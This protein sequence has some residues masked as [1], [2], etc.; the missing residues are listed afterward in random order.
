MQHP[1]LSKV[2][3]KQGQFKKFQRALS[4]IIILFLVSLILNKLSFTQKYSILDLAS[5]EVEREALGTGPGRFNAVVAED[6]DDDGKCE[7]VFGNY[8]GYIIVLEYRDYDFH[9]E[10]RSKKIGHRMWGITVGDFIGDS[11]KEIIAGN[12]N[13][14]LVAFNA[15]TH[16]QVWYAEDLVRDVHGLL[17]HDLGSD[18]TTYLLAGTGYKTDKDLGTVYIF[19]ENST[20][21]IAKIGKFENRLRGIGVGDVDKDG[22]LEIV[23]GS[24]VATG[25]RPGEGYVRVF[26]V[27]D[28]LDPQTLKSDEPIDSEWKSKNLKG[29]CV[30]IEVVDFT[31]D[32]YPDIVV[33][34][35]YRYQAGW[36]RILTYDEAAKDYVEYW[37]SPDIGPKPYGLAVDDV[38]DNNKL[39]IVVSN[40]PGY[41]Y[42]YEQSGSGLKRIWKSKVLGTDI[43]G[44]DIEDVDNDGQLEI[45]ATQGGYVGKG[46]YT[47][48]YSDPHIY[49]IDGKTHEIEIIIGETHPLGFILQ[50][51]ILILTVLFLLGLNYY[52]KYR[53]KVKLFTASKSGG[54][55]AKGQKIQVK[56][57]TRSSQTPQPYPAP[58]QIPQPHPAQKQPTFTSSI[59][60]SVSGPRTSDPTQMQSPVQSQVHA[61]SHTLVSQPSQ[62]KV[63]PKT[64][65]GPPPQVFDPFIKPEQPPPQVF[66][67]FA[68][69]DQPS[70]QPPQPPQPQPQKQQNK[71]PSREVN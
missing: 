30:A 6:I 55:T 47:S 17:L 36:I 51:L 33:G 18:D 52:L 15:K 10:W 49:I 46:D 54:S 35:G 58:N 13:G 1:K 56:S 14:E 25:E 57:P 34:N 20:E 45:V 22:E 16:K 11:T 65:T 69:P 28:A 5:A 37:K 40:Q 9:E 48:G 41:I 43:L 59:P 12:G 7:I 24:G 61:T 27:E 29:D 68:K 50:I 8:E 66:D 42:I 23:V 44:L 39:D 62:P 2:N 71:K 19:T 21:P 64:T 32:G 70:S 3:I 63:S 60:G 26:N 67:P 38:N 4:L 53:R 31:G